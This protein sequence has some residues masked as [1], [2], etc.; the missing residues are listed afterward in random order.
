MKR[1]QGDKGVRFACGLAIV[2]CDR[3]GVAKS[4]MSAR[5]TTKTSLRLIFFGTAPSA[6]FVLATVSMLIAA[7]L[8]FGQAPVNFVTQIPT[9]QTD[10]LTC[11]NQSVA[12]DH[13]AATPQQPVTDNPKERLAVNPV[14]GLVTS[15]A[16]NYRP[17]TG[18]ERWMLYWKQN[19]FSVGA[20]FGP[21][22]TA[23]VLDQATNSPSQ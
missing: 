16:S 17:L 13:A 14:T 10:S 2:G 3:C 22:L 4:R 7:T 5:R 8:S 11:Q 6:R 12:S 15:P 21:V 20:Y 19:Y 9:N 1:D 18:K 23:L